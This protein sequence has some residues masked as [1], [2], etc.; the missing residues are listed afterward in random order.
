MGFIYFLFSET[1]YRKHFYPIKTASN[2]SINDL[3]V[4]TGKMKHKLTHTV[5]VTGP[6]LIPL[7]NYF[8]SLSIVQL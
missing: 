8:L 3:Q 4:D 7:Y 5:K 1:S 2:I 6:S